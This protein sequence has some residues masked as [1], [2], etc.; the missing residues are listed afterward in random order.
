MKAVHIRIEGRVQGV[1][2][3]NYVRDVADSI[4]I[5]GWARNR[6]DGTVEAHA[7][8]SAEQIDS[9]IEACRAGTVMSTVSN[10]IVAE[11]TGMPHYSSFTTI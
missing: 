7:V 10:V 9:M 4:G 5:K 2:Y 6:A 11:L 3:R 1:G 8:G